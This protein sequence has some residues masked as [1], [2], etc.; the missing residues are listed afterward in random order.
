MSTVCSV[1]VGLKSPQRTIHTY[2]AQV[3]HYVTKAWLFEI[4]RAEHRGTKLISDWLFGQP[5]W[6]SLLA[7]RNCVLNESR[8]TGV[9]LFNMAINFTWQTRK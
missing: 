7:G 4:A 5:V 9:W 1:L 8:C 2:F 3:Y 6:F